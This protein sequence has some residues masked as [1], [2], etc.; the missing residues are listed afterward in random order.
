MR[1]GGNGHSSQGGKPLKNRTQNFPRLAGL[2]SG[3]T[4]PIA[5][6]LT[7]RVDGPAGLILL[8]LGDVMPEPTPDEGDEDSH[9]ISIRGGSGP[10]GS[11]EE[12]LRIGVTIPHPPPGN[13]LT[14]QLSQP[15][16]AM[17]V[18]AANIAKGW[19]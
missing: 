11:A 12:V 19:R 10:D 15:T 18:F 5:D 17:Q 16:V 8:R 3:E 7:I 6:G 13:G 9:G 2:R 14:E 1:H 4:V